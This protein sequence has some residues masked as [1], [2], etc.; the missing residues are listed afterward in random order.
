[1]K[2]SMKKRIALAGLTL[3]LSAAS[4]PAQT[5]PQ[6]QSIVLGET[7]TL[8]SSVLKEKRVLN[9][10]VPEGYSAKDTTRYPVIYLLDGGVGEDFIHVAGLLQFGSFEWVHRVPKAILV[11]IGNV[12]RKRDFLFAAQTLSDRQNAPTSGASADFMRFMEQEMLPYVQQ[13]FRV[14][15]QRTLIGQS[16]AGLL[17]TQVLFEKPELFNRY[18]IVSPALWWDNGA[19]LNRETK[20]T[21]ASFT[22]PVQVYLAVGKEGLA[23]CEAPHVMEVDANLLA[24]KLMNAKNKALKV[25]FDYFPEEDHGTILHQAVYKGLGALFR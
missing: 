10:Y 11:G 18:L 25:T 7:H 22:T 6:T 4:A 9:I 8:A 19:L 24:E 15:G 1:M 16:S 23:P 14:N 21:A 2:I 13:H 5:K 17:A 12:D 3:A 20:V